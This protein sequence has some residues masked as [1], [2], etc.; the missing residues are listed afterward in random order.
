METCMFL[1]FH[2]QNYMKAQK[3]ACFPVLSPFKFIGYFHPHPPIHHN[4]KGLLKRDVPRIKLADVS[5]S[6]VGIRWNLAQLSTLSL[7]EVYLATLLLRANGVS[8]K[9]K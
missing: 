4:G 8:I 2:V 7:L 3:H 1:C 5:K 6:V 9:L